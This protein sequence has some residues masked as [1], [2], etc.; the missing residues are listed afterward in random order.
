LYYL[1][2]EIYL[3]ALGCAALIVACAPSKRRSV[4]LAITG[5]VGALLA[6]VATAFLVGD[7]AASSRDELF[8][9]LPIYIR[10]TYVIDPLS[11]SFALLALVVCGLTFLLSLEYIRDR[12]DDHE[13]EF[14]SFLAFASLAVCCLV[15]ARDILTLWFSLE[16][17]SVTGYVMAGFLRA[18]ERS[19]EA[20]IKYF[21]LGAVSSALMLFGFSYLYGITGRLDLGAI[22]VALEPSTVGPILPAAVLLI[23]VGFGFKVAMVPFH[24]WCPD[25]YEGAPTPVTAFL[26]VGPKLAGFAA[27]A[28]VLMTAL[29]G[30]EATAAWG[31]VLALAAVATMTLGNLVALRQQSVKRMLAYSSIAHAGYLLAAIVV[32]NDSRFGLQAVVLYALAYAFMNL[33]AFAVVLGVSHVT[34]DDRLPSYDGLSLRSPYLA[35]AWVVFALSLVGI[36]PTSGFFGKL[37]ILAATVEGHQLWLGLAI[38]L[39]SMVSLYYYFA[40]TRRMYFCQPLVPSRIRVGGGLGFAIGCAIAGT[41]L[42]FLLFGPLTDAIEVIG[43]A[44]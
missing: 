7:V 29:S 21:L 26:S 39:N 16:L 27:L 22:Q 32:L 40:V 18:E 2:P 14:L 19:I 15:S 42:L 44:L 12:L 43:R 33:G 38:V 17:L 36:P 28:R 34:G 11:R 41:L 10:T 23:L 1:L 20:A 6:A 24:M 8:A 9:S 35:G 3:C 5:G 31:P 13:P 37:Y 30:D 25:V 4:G